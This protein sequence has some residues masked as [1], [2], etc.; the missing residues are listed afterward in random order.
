MNNTIRLFRLDWCSPV[1]KQ[2]QLT[3]YFLDSKPVTE[4]VECQL[5]NSFVK[6]T[7][8]TVEKESK[9]FQEALRWQKDLKKY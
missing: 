7:T 8:V 3:Y 5:V 4:V 2:N 1:N 9:E 6:V